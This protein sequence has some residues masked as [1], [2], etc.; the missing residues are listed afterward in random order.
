M[1]VCGGRG[2]VHLGAPLIQPT[3][4]AGHISDNHARA[5]SKYGHTSQQP[6]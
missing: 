6:H 5:D 3:T 2:G 1:N 4:F